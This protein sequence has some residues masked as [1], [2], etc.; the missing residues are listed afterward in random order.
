[1]TIKELI[2]MLQQELEKGGEIE[3]CE[4]HEVRFATGYTS[5]DTPDGAVLLSIYKAE[6]KK[7]VWIDVG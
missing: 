3:G 1:M 2:E 4:D 6:K 5:E 7:V